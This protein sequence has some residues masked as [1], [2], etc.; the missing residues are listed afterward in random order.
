[1]KYS[2]KQI[3]ILLGRVETCF[4]DSTRAKKFAMLVSRSILKDSVGDIMEVLTP[5]PEPLC[6]IRKAGVALST[7]RENTGESIPVYC[8]LSC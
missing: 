6:V 8:G 7:Q 4:N 5:L 1:M 3:S 2:I